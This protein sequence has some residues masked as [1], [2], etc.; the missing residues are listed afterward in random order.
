MILQQSEDNNYII[1]NKLPH[2]WLC[3]LIKQIFQIRF[4]NVD[5]IEANVVTDEGIC[6]VR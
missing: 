4:F 3:H 1:P 5:L 2:F 6:D